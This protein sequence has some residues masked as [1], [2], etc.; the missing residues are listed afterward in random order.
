MSRDSLHDLVDRIPDEEIQA[1]HRAALS[2]SPDDEPV[3]EADT[4]AIKRAKEEI[5]NGK[6]VSHTDVL[7]EFGVT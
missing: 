1:A 3:T 5:G 2:A 4:A 7:S 6:T